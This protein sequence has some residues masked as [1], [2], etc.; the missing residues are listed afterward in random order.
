MCPASQ[1]KIR[2]ALQEFIFSEE[3]ACT[4][5]IKLNDGKIKWD[6]WPKR[7]VII[8]QSDQRRLRRRQDCEAIRWG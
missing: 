6:K 1:R 3:Q 8:G 2:Y 7:E 4:Y 5:E